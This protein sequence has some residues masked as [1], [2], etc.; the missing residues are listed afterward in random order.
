[1]VA[2]DPQSRRAAGHSHHH[3]IST[4]E[5]ALST[6]A[7]LLLT[8][9]GLHRGG[10]LGLGGIALGGLLLVRGGTGHCNVKGL[11]HDPQMELRHLRARV[12]Q[13]SA[14]LARI[15]AQRGIARGGAS[16]EAF[17]AAQT[18]GGSYAVDP[19]TA[20]RMTGHA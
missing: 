9:L 2:F 18:P 5:R 4:V 3:N 8:G 10:I 11:L 17:D 12:R 19:S 16:D 6:G 7:G 20:S 14:A 1:M 15:S 13:L